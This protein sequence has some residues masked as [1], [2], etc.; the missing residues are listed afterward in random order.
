MERQRRRRERLHQR[1]VLGNSVRRVEMV[2]QSYV[3]RI[4][5]RRCQRKVS[6]RPLFSS[7]QASRFDF[8]VSR[9]ATY[10]VC[11]TLSVRTTIRTTVRSTVRSRFRLP[12]GLSNCSA[13]GRVAG[14][15]D[16]FFIRNECPG[17]SRARTQVVV[18]DELVDR[19]S[20]DT[21]SYGM[22]LRVL[23]RKNMDKLSVTL[24]GDPLTGGSGTGSMLVR[25]VV[26][27]SPP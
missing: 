23:G 25:F 1:T 6:S 5:R 20:T 18:M 21:Q 26:E 4:L 12:D 19:L 15:V 27:R 10:R 11:A 2:V 8:V 14:T 17:G 7:L 24:S 22:A 3:Y 13:V 16:F 9:I